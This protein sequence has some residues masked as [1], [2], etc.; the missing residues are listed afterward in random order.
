M[1]Q[2]VSDP[3]LA[4]RLAV[5]VVCVLAPSVLFVLFDRWLQRLRDD[6]FVQ[7]VMARVDEERP[8]DASGRAPA[9]VLTG[10]VA[11]GGTDQVRCDSCGARNPTV[12]S[13]CGA[14]LNEL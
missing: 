2:P 10:G 3:E 7:R 1:D 9:T 14:C 6:E 4:G 5:A 13:Y 8:A 12:A 11:D